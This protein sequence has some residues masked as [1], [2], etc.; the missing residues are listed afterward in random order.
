MAKWIILPS[1]P[2]FI[3]EKQTIESIYG[4]SAPTVVE[5]PD[6]LIPSCIWNKF[7]TRVSGS[8]LKSTWRTNPAEFESRKLKDETPVQFRWGFKK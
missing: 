6:D 8:Q 4:I 7:A 2:A 1:D 3:G 5:T